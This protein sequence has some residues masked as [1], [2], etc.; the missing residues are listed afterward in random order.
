MDVDEGPKE[1]VNLANALDLSESEDEEELE[2][3]IDDFSLTNDT[4]EVCSQNVIAS[5]GT[6]HSYYRTQ[7]SDKSGYISSSFPTRFLPLSLGHRNLLPMSLP[8]NLPKPMMVKRK[9]LSL[10]TPS[11]QLWVRLPALLGLLRHKQNRKKTPKWMVSLGNLKSTR[12]GQSRC[13]LATVY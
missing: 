8:P 11:H 4:E 3:I 5:I 10:K 12:V 13:A 6:Q 9:S 7:T 1:E 2:D